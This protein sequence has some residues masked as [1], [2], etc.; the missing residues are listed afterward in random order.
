[1]QV[2]ALEGPTPEDRARGDALAEELPDGDA[3]VLAEVRQL[4]ARATD[5]EEAREYAPS[6]R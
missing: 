1:M 6:S 2:Y 4:L 3:A 5:G